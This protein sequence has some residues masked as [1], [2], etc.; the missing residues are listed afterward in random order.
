M[1]EKR[2][3]IYNL[4]R[5]HTRDITSAMFDG[6]TKLGRNVTMVPNARGWTGRTP[7]DICVMY[8]IHS[9][10]RKV[11]RAYVEAGKKI[12]FIDNG[13]FG[14]MIGE[15]RFK[16]Y[17]RFSVGGMHPG[18]YIIK[19]RHPP[20]RWEKFA[21][22]FAQRPRRGKAIVVAGMSGKVARLHKLREW[23]FQMIQHLDRITDRPIWY[24]PK[25]A[26]PPPIRY[27]NAK[28]LDPKIKVD[29]V[30][31]GAHAVVTRHSNMALEA[32]AF[33]VPYYCEAGA[34]VALSMKLVEIERPR[35]VSF[36]D[37]LQ[38]LSNVCYAQW[39]V[40]EMRSGEAWASLEKDG[41]V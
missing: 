6:L 31:S 36:V 17:H 16:T 38:L 1:R 40:A 3:V 23:D 34:A 37:R 22:R 26:C 41:L 9:T 15:Q 25:R 35:A 8:A 13:Y 12:V 7:G 27:T 11:Y 18:D 21:K 39:N 19:Q 32:L 33:G 20:D 2:I 30:L 29:E 14:R 5:P 28:I 10:L 4:Q 24:K